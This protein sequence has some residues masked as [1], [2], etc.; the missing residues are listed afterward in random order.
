MTRLKSLFGRRSNAVVVAYLGLLTLIPALFLPAVTIERF[1]ALSTY[2][3]VSSVLELANAGNVLIA[4]II[5]LFSALFPVLKLALVL[6]LAMR[7][8]PRAGD[9]GR[10]LVKFMLAAGKYSMLDVFVIALL[11]VAFKL[12]GVIKAEIDF[13]LY[14]FILSIVLSTLANLMLMASLDPASAETRK[15]DEMSAP[16]E[17]RAKTGNRRGLVRPVV[18]ILLPLILG[19]LGA[20]LYF[21]ASSGT[22]ATVLVQRLPGVDLTIVSTPDTP[23]YALQL[24]FRN[25]ELY[26]SPSKPDTPIGNGIV[27]DIPDVEL[28]LLQEISLWDDNSLTISDMKLSVLPDAIVDRVRIGETRVVEGQRMRFQLLGEPAPQRTVALFVLGA[29]GIWL[30]IGLGTYLVGLTRR[31]A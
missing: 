25:G 9:S 22:V 31:Q 1:G 30:V 18:L 29:A 23:D 15:G 26:R 17:Q 28:S 4:G 13:G 7:P 16:E 8:T 11:I 27:F 2:S 21:T 6:Y 14:L 12:G 20:A 5:F 3:I 10:S 19:V 24:L